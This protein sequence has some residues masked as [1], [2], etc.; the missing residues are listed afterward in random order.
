MVQYVTAAILPLMMMTLGSV[1][2]YMACLSSPGAWPDDCA[3][4]NYIHPHYTPD[5][6]SIGSI[7]NL[8]EKSS[9]VNTNV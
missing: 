1:G 9:H 6:M 5:S 3:L 8:I 4:G 2:S 7:T